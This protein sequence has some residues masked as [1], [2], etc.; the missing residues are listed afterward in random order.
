M[1]L[2]RLFFKKSDCLLT[3]KIWLIRSKGTWLLVSIIKALKELVS[4]TE[5]SFIKSL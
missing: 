2:A 3:I 5:A 4:K 1:A